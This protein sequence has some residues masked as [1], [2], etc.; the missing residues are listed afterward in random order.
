MRNRVFVSTIA[1]MI[2]CSVISL[3][4]NA[5][6]CNW[7]CFMGDTGHTGFVQNGC[8][9][10]KT[11][12]SKVWEFKTS[13]Y[14]QSSIVLDGNYAYFGSTDN[15]FYCLDATK[16]TKI[17]DYYIGES[18]K[19]SKSETIQGVVSTA[20][21][22]N[23]Y[24]Y[25]GT[26]CG[27][28][29]CLDAKNGNKKWEHEELLVGSFNGPI[30]TD[31]D[32]VY[33]ISDQW[34]YCLDAYTGSQKWSEIVLN[35]SISAPVIGGNRL[36][37][38]AMYFMKCFD[39][40]T[41]KELSSSNFW[42]SGEDIYSASP[43]Y[44]NGKVY[45][46]CLDSKFFRFDGI[47]G[48]RDWISEYVGCTTSIC[49][50]ND[51]VLFGDYLKRLICLNEYSGTLKW[52]FPADNYI[53][54][55]PIFTEN[56]IFFGST[57]GT[58]YCLD[59]SGSMVWSY[60]FNDAITA[61][62]SVANGMV[63]IGSRDGS[64]ACFSDNSQNKPDKI[65]VTATKNELM[66]GESVQLQASVFSKNGDLLDV[67]VVWSCEPSYLGSI[68]QDGYFTAGSSSGKVTIKAS[69]GNIVG[70]YDI[71]IKKIEDTISRI[72][73]SS[74]DSNLLIGT[75]YQ[76]SAKAYD[77]N[78]N[79]ID[80]IKY[81]WSVEPFDM[82]FINP[83]GMFTP[84]KE[85]ECNITATVGNKSGFVTVTIG[86]IANIELKPENV[87]IVPGGKVRFV[88]SV[89]DTKGNKISNPVLV[90]TVEPYYI[91]AIDN[92]GTFT[93]ARDANGQIGNVIVEGYGIKKTAEIRI[94]EIKKSELEFDT[95]VLD[96]GQIDPGQSI[97]KYITITNKG[98][99]SE[100]VK[101]STNSSWMTIDPQTIDI[102]PSKKALSQI[103]LVGNQME[104]GSHFEGILNISTLSGFTSTVV[105]KVTVS[106]KSPTCLETRPSEL[107][108]G[109]VGRG[110]SISVPLQVKNVSKSPVSGQI[111]P[112][113]SWIE[114]TPNS[115]TDLQANIDVT[116]SIKGSAIPSLDA[117]E[118][119]IKIVTSQDCEPVVVKVTGS[120][121]KKI[122]I[123]LTINKKMGYINDNEIEL[124]VPPKKVNGRTL[125]PIRFLSEAFGCSILWDSKEGK[126][127]INKGS[128][129]IILYKD[130]NK[131]F[132]NGV[133]KSLDVPA[134]ISSGRTLVP[135]RFIAEAFGAIVNFDA[136]SNL[137]TIEYT[138]N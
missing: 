32:R 69:V 16:G 10:K 35:N 115:F 18:C 85:G 131:A 65:T 138:P 89:F 46:G 121:D 6:S 67:P 117:F 122:A 129:E 114:V 106:K 45:F 1:L 54:G 91:G 9:P 75:D 112:T 84:K 119:S 86:K 77:S 102:D 17:W 72:E 52:A 23:G 101:L 55:G 64:V 113:E 20:T 76:F 37:A 47:S 30:I 81:Y 109:K 19:N 87:D 62:P 33:A 134:T 105:I 4:T 11:E 50:T 116:V 103:T 31:G 110:K 38:G 107:Y 88:A 43:A 71:T 130:K 99:A 120:T 63:Y 15:K 21:V 135:I 136:K 42:T 61:P 94:N 73:V 27:K 36:Y 5:A 60:K 80:S 118:G 125:V 92:Y 74:P 111:I 79:F 29:I 53:F 90:W 3:N 39:P 132:V 98:S 14:V 58:F 83:D 133:E 127:T 13:G 59:Q 123:K 97:S 40:V 7:P 25:F 108:V 128:L 78:N 12:L 22:S 95:Q 96:Y 124:D 137:I 2:M 93:A 48:E 41:G 104:K 70:K 8:G 57:S 126:I 100:T 66:T 24:V 28:V 26:I 82:G 56:K 34:I 49:V 68:T 44:K 51:S